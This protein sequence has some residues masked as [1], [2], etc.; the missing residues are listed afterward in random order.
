V[1]VDAHHHV[2]D[3]AVRDQ[4]WTA[5]LP[6]LRRSFGLAQLWPE[7]TANGIDATVVVQTIC[8]REETPELLELASANKWVVGVVGW[9]ELTDAG[10]VDELD[11]LRAS[12]GG[13]RLV[14]IRHQ[15]Q[16]EPDP[17]WLCR[18]DVRN[19]L[20][21]VADSG[22]AYD[23][24]VTPSQLPSAI[25]TARDLPQLRFVLDHAGKPD[26][27]GGRVAPWRDDI[28]ALAALPNVAVKLSGLTTQADP[29][30]WS[31]EQLRPYADEVL[32]RFGP[33]RVMFGSDWPVCLL[34]SSYDDVVDTACVLTGSLSADERDA[35][36]GRTAARWY[37]L[38]L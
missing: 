13:E 29:A 7:V 31:V 25:E 6:L 32:E 2:W 23:L 12:P 3:L 22:L 20:R 35:V 11:A 38:S 10:V 17:R 5:S 9:V 19:G 14:G 26:I 18:P 30:A 27:A 8:V 21:A 15:V 28:A 1:R 36:F 4:P 24:L 16:D 34:A 37:E 33:Q